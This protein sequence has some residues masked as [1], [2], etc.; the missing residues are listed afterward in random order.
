LNPMIYRGG[1]LIQSIAVVR[2]GSTI[3][4]PRELPAIRLLT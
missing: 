4:L 3:L 2:L 1:I